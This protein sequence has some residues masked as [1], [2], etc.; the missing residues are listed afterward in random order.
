MLG[1]IILAALTAVA[2][3]AAHPKIGGLVFAA[4]SSGIYRSADAGRQWQRVS[5][6]PLNTLAFI[7]V[8]ALAFNPF[9]D[10]ELCALGDSS[11][12]CSR[13]LGATWNTFPQP[14]LNFLLFDPTKRDRMFMGTPYGSDWLFVSD[15]H[16]RDW[17]ARGS[18][19]VHP[20]FH[21]SAAV[22]PRTGAI[23]ESG[24]PHGGC[25]PVCSLFRS[26][27]AGSTWREIV[28]SE[29]AWTLAVDRAGHS[30]LYV[31]SAGTISASTDLGATFETRGTVP[32]STSVLASDPNSV[33]TICAG[34]GDGSVLQSFDGGRHWRRIDG[35]QI[36][37]PITHLSVGIDG[38]V[39]AATQNSVVALSAAR[40]RRAAGR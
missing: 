23:V 28:A 25:I 26:D 18:L 1:T 21:G 11:M 33:N 20:W 12:S 8:H 22:D 15:D 35:A 3:L 10:S 5:D 14:G 17:S 13:D 39:Y 30:V 29:D 19:D 32:F 9:D 38:T 31:I 24:S 27:D 34:S 6:A 2:D 37:D 40:H 36:R 4:T 16:G 7:P